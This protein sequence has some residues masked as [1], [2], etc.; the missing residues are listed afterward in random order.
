VSPR[1]WR[2]RIQ[3]ILD[4][5]AEIQSFTQGMDF[6]SF[7]VDDKTIRAVELN[8]IIIGEVASQ[9]SNEVE[10]Q[11]PKIPGISCAQCATG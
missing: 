11:Y 9:I 7:R 8:F 5:I 6:E 4:A 10:E 1:H 3:D 2:E